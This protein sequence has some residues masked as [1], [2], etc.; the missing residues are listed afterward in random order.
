M[1][2]YRL[3][4]HYNPIKNCKSFVKLTLLDFKKL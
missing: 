4:K 1:L 2:K 3:Y